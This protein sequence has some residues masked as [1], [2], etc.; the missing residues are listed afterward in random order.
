MRVL[1]TLVVGGLLPLTIAAPYEKRQT[2]SL[3]GLLGSN[4]GAP[5]LQG[6]LMSLSSSIIEMFAEKP[7]KVTD[8]EGQKNTRPDSKHKRYWLG[9]YEVPAGKVRSRYSNV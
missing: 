1:F 2:G 8:I 7:A 5:G 3:L 9:P 6:T 4:S